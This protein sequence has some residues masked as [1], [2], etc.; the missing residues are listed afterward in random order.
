VPAHRPSPPPLRSQAAAR[1]AAGAARGALAALALIT[2]AGSAAA[3]PRRKR[4]A[5]PATAPD[6]AAAV[7]TGDVVAQCRAAIATARAG[8]HARASFVLPAC[9]AAVAQVPELADAARAA[10]L[11]VARV[12]DKQDRSPVELVLRPV[13]AEGTL[14]ID[15]FP[16]LPVSEGRVRLPAGHYRITGRGAH[17]AVAYDLDL[18]DG[19][20]AL[21]LVELPTRPARATAGVVD[22]TDG[23]PTPTVAGPPP[24]IRRES[25]LPERFRRGL[26]KPPATRR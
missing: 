1:V 24:K 22:F 2:T 3:G 11:A 17:G 10:R 5:A 6:L 20:R 13:G 16:G 15:A 8:E 9:D 19:S 23:E 26:G 12:A 14:A 25:L 21:V 4:P 7:A 18:A